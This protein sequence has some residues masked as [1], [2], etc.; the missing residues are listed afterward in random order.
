MIRVTDAT[1]LVFPE[2]VKDPTLITPY[3]L[4]ECDKNEAQVP[5]R[6][7]C[8]AMPS[9]ESSKSNVDLFTVS[10]DHRVHL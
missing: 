1:H 2:H 10:W 8:G 3:L 4:I 6:T 7:K 5:A 9:I